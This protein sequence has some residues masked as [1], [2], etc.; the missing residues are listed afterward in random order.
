MILSYSSYKASFISSS[1]SKILRRKRCFYNILN[2]FN[3]IKIRALGR[4]DKVLDTV[5]LFILLSE[6]SF[7]YAVRRVSILL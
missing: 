6:A 1:E 5:G 4:I 7:S 3:R 2:T